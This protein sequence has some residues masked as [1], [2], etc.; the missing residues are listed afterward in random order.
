MRGFFFVFGS[1][2]PVR[3]QHECRCRVQSV[4]GS[5]LM[6]PGIFDCC[7]ASQRPMNVVGS[8]LHLVVAWSPLLRERVRGCVVLVCLYVGL[9]GDLRLSRALHEEGMPP[10]AKWQENVPQFDE[11]TSAIFRSI[12]RFRTCVPHRACINSCTP[13]NSSTKRA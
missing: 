13:I 3:N 1:L 11:K 10:Y 8:L 12:Q 7:S 5:L 6:R 9:S 2:E 4:D